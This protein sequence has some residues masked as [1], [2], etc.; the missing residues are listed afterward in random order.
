MELVC[1]KSGERFPFALNFFNNP[2]TNSE[3][4]SNLILDWGYKVDGFQSLVP[5]QKKVH[6]YGAGKTPLIENIEISHILEL[7]NLFIKDESH[8]P[9]GT[10]KDRRSEYII[11]VAV[12]HGVDK[13]VCLTAGNAGY[14][15]SRYCNKANID[16]TSLIFPWISDNRRNELDHWGNVT[17]IDGNRYRWI[18]R[19]R[20]FRKIIEEHDAYERKKYW[21]NIWAVTNSFEPISINAYK[22][23]FYEVKDKN[24]DYIVIPCGS[25]DIIVGIW[26]AIEELG[27]STR[28]IAVWPEWEHPLKKALELGVDEFQLKDYKEISIADKLSTPF[29]AILPILKKIFS[30]TIH[31]YLEVSNDDITHGKRIAESNGIRC[32]ASAA[33]GFWIFLSENRPQI[34][35]KSQVIIVSTWKGIE[36]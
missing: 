27:V 34:D 26:L 20:D 33:V 5:F 19:S 7:E 23:L 15:L 22:E 16:Y 6:S 29:T 18:L 17:T 24:P 36:N 14:S 25:G 10:H 28:I 12:E 32:E 2:K 1:I 35:P 3:E 9:Y 30:G 13:I 8:N 4:Y 11:N 21:N 31:Q